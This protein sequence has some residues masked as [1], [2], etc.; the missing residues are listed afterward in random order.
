MAPSKSGALAVALLALLVSPP[1]LSS[2]S[3]T[4]ESC[5]ALEGI[6]RTAVEAALRQ[7]IALAAGLLRIFFHDCFPQGCDASVLL[8]GSGSE[9]QLAPNLTLQPR[10][11]QLI[12]DIRAQV[13]AACGPTVSCADIT[14]LATRDAVH[15]SGGPL[16]DVPLG[17]LDSLAPAPSSAVFQLPQASSDASTL[18]N[19]FQSRNL[20]EVDLV[21]LSGGGHTVGRARC[22]SFSNRFGESGAFARRLAANCSADAG[23]L[24]ELDVTTPDAFDN[25]Y[26]VN[27]QN[28][29][30]VLTSDQVLTGDW[31]TSWVVDGFAGNQW[32]FFGQF[33]QSM[34]KLG[35]LKPGGNAAGEIRRNCA[36]PNNAPQNNNNM[37]LHLLQDSAAGVD[38]GF[39]DEGLAASA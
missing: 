5:P 14:A 21:A 10:A 29:E 4:L 32:W 38:Q 23:R 34:V 15:A 37:L 33:G 36:K 26:Y 39:A 35:N 17:R 6:V 11:L 28:G 31:R 24:Q 7:D 2:A 13:H 25:K 18:I 22:S 1:A 20:S 19:A 9:Q 8:T 16:Y 12:E 3:T 30:G 27:L